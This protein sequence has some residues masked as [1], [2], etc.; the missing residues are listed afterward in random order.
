VPD[1]EETG[2]GK[3]SSAK[4]STADLDKVGKEP[5]LTGPGARASKRSQEPDFDERVLGR[6]K[7]G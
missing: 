2:G 6:R 5:R 3:K 7:K 1:A 4:V